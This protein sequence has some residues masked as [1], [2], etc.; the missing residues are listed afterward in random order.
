PSVQQQ[1]PPDAALVFWIDWSHPGAADPGAFHYACVVRRQGAPAWVRLPGSGPAHA[2]TD[3]DGTLPER[4]REALAQRS[5]AAATLAQQLHAQRLEPLAPH[6]AAT[7]G[8]PAVTRLIAVPAGEMAGIP[9]DALSDR[10]AVSYAPSGTVFARLAANHRPLRNPTLLALGDPAFAGPKP[11][12]P[13]PP[14]YGLLVQQVLPDSNGAKAGL[15]D[16]DV[17]LAYNGSEL[18]RLADLQVRSDGGPVPARVWRD[19]TARDLSLA[20]GKL[21][22]VFHKE[23]APVVLRERQE[24]VTL[25]ASTRGLSANPLPGTRREVQALAGLFPKE[26]TTV[27]LGSEASEQRLDDL[28][29][30]GRLQAVRIVHLATHGHIDDVSAGHSALLLAADRLPDEAEQVKQNK[31][32]YTGRL[33]VAA[34]AAWQLDAD[35]VTLSACETGLGKK[36]VGDGFLGFTHVLLKAGARSRVVSL[37]KVYDAAPALLLTRFYENMLGRR[38][39][40]ASPLGR[41]AALRE[42]QRWLR[43]LPRAQAEVL[44]ARLSGG[45]LRGTVSA[46]KPPAPAAVVP[47]GT[48]DRPYAHPYYWSAFILLG[49]SD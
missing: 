46:L 28:A 12:R 22:V 32:V 33:T 24:F 25:V 16:N 38:D 7:A 20:P 43:T 18:R 48:E 5:P 40:L 27:L 31:K 1:L 19:G 4:L 2:W 15:R 39:G 23:P 45:E 36:A 9:L 30:A 37:W 6:L 14:T 42:A 35:L 44:S 41:A 13:E 49:D 29:A 34:L 26:R 10:Y 11:N 21:G 8:L 47:T 3:E 17:L